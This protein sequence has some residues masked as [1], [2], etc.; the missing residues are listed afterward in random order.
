VFFEFARDPVGRTPERNSFV[1]SGPADA[2]E[3]VLTL[4]H[5]GV[6]NL[7]FEVTPRTKATTQLEMRDDEFRLHPVFAPFFEYSHRRKRR[8]TF[9]AEVLLDVFKNPAQALATLLGRQPTD[10][11][12]LPRQLAMFS[13]F[14]QPSE[15]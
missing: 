9:S 13:E 4:L 10:I 5:E 15:K 11:E 2:R 14:Y 6:S 7:A 8:S 1:I 3:K 12:E